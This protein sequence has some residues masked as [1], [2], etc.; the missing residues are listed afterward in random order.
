MF[1]DDDGVA[2]A[3]AM[4]CDALWEALDRV[5]GAREW[6]VKI[7][8]DQDVLHSH[9]SQDT[10]GVGAGP[11]QINA[12]SAGRAFFMRRQMEHR[13]AQDVRD[14]IIRRIVESGRLLSTAARTAAA[15]RIQP[16]AIHG[17]ADEMVCNSAFLVAREQENRFLAVI[18]GLR[19]VSP[20]SGFDYELNGPWAPCSFAHFSL[21]SA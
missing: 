4:H 19:D 9:L 13:A 2:T 15:L 5:D 21:G 16:P 1:S 10:D 20:R 12:P 3:L 14:S 18:D 17:R 11:A 7:F 6:G 8:C